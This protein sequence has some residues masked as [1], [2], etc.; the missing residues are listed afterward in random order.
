MKKTDIYYIYTYVFLQKM[1]SN[2]SHF[3]F[4]EI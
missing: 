2:I 1:I 3:Y 4:D